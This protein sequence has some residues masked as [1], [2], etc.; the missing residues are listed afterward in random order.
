MTKP[1]VGMKAERI[2]KGFWFWKHIT[3]NALENENLFPKDYGKWQIELFRYK[4]YTVLIDKVEIE[5][6]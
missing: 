4:P 2:T 6:K 1:V 5:K 3:I